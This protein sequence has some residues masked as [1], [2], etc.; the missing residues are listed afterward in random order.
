MGTGRNPG[1][2]PEIG[3]S[4]A[5]AGAVCLEHQGHQLDTRLIVRGHSNHSYRLAWSPVSVQARRGWNDPG[6]AT[7]DG[8]AGIAVILANQ[9]VGYMVIARSRKGTGFDYLLGDRDVLNVSDTERVA[10]AGWSQI[11]DDA[12]LIVRGRMEVS[13]I[14]RGNDSTVR[15]RGE[16]EAGSDR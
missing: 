14:M 11:L 5:Q 2:T 4:L 15:A 6:E 10:T 13:G 7:E 16:F 9:E 12:S 1:I 8:A 3:N